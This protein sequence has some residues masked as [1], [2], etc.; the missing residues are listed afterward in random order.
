MFIIVFL[1]CYIL[2][3][4]FLCNLGKVWFWLSLVIG[5]LG[6][7]FFVE[8]YTVFVGFIKVNG[9]GL[10]I[11]LLLCNFFFKISKNKKIKELGV[12]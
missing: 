10:E 4:D 6:K 5:F 8:F 7:L 3:D 9:G 2:L 12:F 11:Y 1:L